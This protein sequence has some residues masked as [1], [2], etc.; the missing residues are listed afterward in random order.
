MTNGI[1]RCGV[2]VR[3]EPHEYKRMTFTYRRGYAEPMS[4]AVVKCPELAVD[5]PY[6]TPRKRGIRQPRLRHGGDT[7]ALE[8]H[9]SHHDDVV[10]GMHWRNRKNEDLPSRYRSLTITEATVLRDELTRAID[11]AVTLTNEETDK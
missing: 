8:V 6:E 1:V 2:D 10:V 5:L 11:A 4:A 7:I 3:H 9:R